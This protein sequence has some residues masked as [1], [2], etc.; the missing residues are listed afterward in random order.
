MSEMSINAVADHLNLEVN[1]LMSVIR[2][3]QPYGTRM[4]LSGEH[5]LG[6]SEL[7]HAGLAQNIMDGQTEIKQDA[8]TMYQNSS[9]SI[10]GQLKAV[11]RMVAELMANLSNANDRITIRIVETLDQQIRE[12]L[13]KASVVVP[14]LLGLGLVTVQR[15][16]T[17]AELVSRLKFLLD[18]DDRKRK[19]KYSTSSESGYKLNKESYNELVYQLRSA[20]QAFA[21]VQISKEAITGARGKSKRGTLLDRAATDKASPKNSLKKKWV[22][23]GEGKDT[24]D[25]L[26]HHVKEAESK[27]HDLRTQLKTSVHRRLDDSKDASFSFKGSSPAF[28]GLSEV[29]LISIKRNIDRALEILKG[30]KGRSTSLFQSASPWSPHKSKVKKGQS[31]LEMDKL[32]LSQQESLKNL[33]ESSE[34]KLEGT[35]AA[36]IGGGWVGCHLASTLA[37]RGMKITLFEPKGQVLMRVGG[38]SRW[39][40]K[41]TQGSY[42]SNRLESGARYPS[43]PEIRDQCINGSKEFLKLYGNL[44]KKS[45]CLFAIGQEDCDG[46]PSR[47]DAD[48]FDR[49]IEQLDPHSREE[50]PATLGITGVNRLWR[51]SE[52]LIPIDNPG[53]H[54][55]NLFEESKNITL[56]TAVQN[57]SHTAGSPSINGQRFDWVI[58]CTNFQ[59]H[60][61]GML[62]NF[63][64]YHPY[65]KLLYTEKKRRVNPLHLTVLDG[66]FCSFEPLLFSDPNELQIFDGLHL[67]AFNQ[68]EPLYSFTHKKFSQCGGLACKSVD[69]AKIHLSKY[70]GYRVKEEL[71]PLFEQDI[72]R[73]YPNFSREFEFVGYSSSII[74]QVSSRDV[75]RGCV[76]R[77]EGTK[78][79][80][81]YSPRLTEIFDAEQSV[82]KVLLEH[83]P[84]EGSK[85]D[86]FLDN[87]RNYIVQPFGFA[88]RISQ[89]QFERVFLTRGLRARKPPKQLTPRASRSPRAGLGGA[90]FKVEPQSITMPS[91]YVNS[92][93]LLEKDRFGVVRYIGPV[94]FADG[95]WFGIEL[96]KSMGAHD[97]QVKKNG[98]R[99]FFCAE[100]RGIF[101]QGNQIRKVFNSKSQSSNSFR[102]FKNLK[103]P[104]VIRQTKRKEQWTV[105]DVCR[106][107]AQSGLL[108]LITKLK[109]NKIDG[110]RLIFS[111]TEG[112]LNSLRISD[113][114]ILSRFKK[115]HLEL[116]DG[117]GTRI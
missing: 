39:R 107:A 87:V 62:S 44:V 109:Y 69:I 66:N 60:T 63:I 94:E 74:T 70:S 65:I 11:E 64:T 15:L 18:Q 32:F 106:W 9:T 98:K 111:S 21:Q 56:S 104:D 57:L 117:G 67:H 14:G 73:F 76:L 13:D 105:E 58:N 46:H 49:I 8:L 40:P 113:P 114:T 81:V 4:S 1:S 100:N 10:L 29:K 103:D 25:E 95:E 115:E 20:K 19:E 2:G 17:L 28:A 90:D 88:S 5:Y 38:P 68:D 96:L 6:D 92:K 78:V 99:Y 108:S 30:L 89:G 27:I 33:L 86:I 91:V 59:E 45:A 35:H 83:N 3:G 24:A 102:R 37:N 48:L 101:V 22:V 82:L 97:G 47:T 50:N 55:L 54:F 51:S 72:R 31:E 84:S 116:I 53:T 110:R 112:L 77:P 16:N 71:R 42:A 85:R 79:L 26:Q 43:N 93:V 75:F 7:L 61:Q 36:V 41:L 52:T 23:E 34:K 12:L 80:H